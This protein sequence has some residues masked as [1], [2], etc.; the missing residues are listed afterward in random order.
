MPKTY[1][2][3][4]K[5]EKGNTETVDEV[6]SLKELKE[7]LREYGITDT[8]RIYYGSQRSTKEWREKE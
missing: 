8:S 4:T 5:D 2:I 3:N 7:Y 1:Y 6:Y